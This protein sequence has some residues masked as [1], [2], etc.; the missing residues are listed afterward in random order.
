MAN[1]NT[2]HSVPEDLKSFYEGISEDDLAAVDQIAMRVNKRVQSIAGK[3]PLLYRSSFYIGSAIVVCGIAL[4]VLFS[5]PSQES[6]TSSLIN[7]QKT[8]LNNPG[9]NNHSIG[10]GIEEEDEKKEHVSS[11]EITKTG[12]LNKE[13]KSIQEGQQLNELEQ[14]IETPLKNEEKQIEK[15]QPIVDE[16]RRMV[17]EE[18][19]LIFLRIAQ[20]AVMGKTDLASLSG[21]S[22]R[23]TDVTNPNIGAKTSTKTSNNSYSLED[24][25]YHTG[26][27]QGLISYISRNLNNKIHIRKKDAVYSVNVVFEV[28]AK[29][30]VEN[31]EILDD[32]P[33]P[34]ADVIKQVILNDTGWNAGKKSGKKGA[35]QLIVN[36]SFV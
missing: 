28:T 24:M 3:A 1:L 5:Y 18:N 10:G 17:E 25:P 13:E 15:S 34:M 6:A 30:K 31:V 26:G 8:I 29:G 14:T 11:N 2:Y 19:V 4:A 20:V 27:D 23:N 33:A 7:T 32:I 35:L 12:Q 9:E 22:T 21:T 36:I 16:T